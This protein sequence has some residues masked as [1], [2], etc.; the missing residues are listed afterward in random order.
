[1][2]VFLYFTA[3]SIFNSR[4]KSNSKSNSNSNCQIEITKMQ[5]PKNEPVYILQT[6]KGHLGLYEPDGSNIDISS[7]DKL[8]LYCPGRRNTLIHS[9]DSSAELSCNSNFYDRVHESNCT[10]PVVGDLVT[11]TNTCRLNNRQGLIYKA[12]FSYV[13]KFVES[14]AICYDS[15]RAS[16]LY[17]H[18]RINGKAIR[19]K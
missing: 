5:I 19:C 9:T 11:T 13:R 6:S 4:S 15:M 2:N 16:V 1:M 14:F 18:H 12:G 10:K 8:I 3:L 7:N 17:T